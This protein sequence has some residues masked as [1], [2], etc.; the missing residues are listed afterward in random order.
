V[1]EGGVGVFVKY[2]QTG[3]AA[4]AGQAVFVIQ[5]VPNNDG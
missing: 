5:Y 1:A 4:T 3:T 2:A